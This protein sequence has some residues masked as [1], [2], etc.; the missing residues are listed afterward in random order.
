VFCFNPENED[1]NEVDNS[2]RVRFPPLL[3]DFP[4][5]QT[6]SQ[7]FRVRWR[8][9]SSVDLGE[10][11]QPTIQNPFFHLCGG[12]FWHLVSI[13]YALIQVLVLN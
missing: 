7:A 6:H 11:D 1:G 8:H 5:A 2:K 12:K 13:M 9:I 4:A 10:N 3:P